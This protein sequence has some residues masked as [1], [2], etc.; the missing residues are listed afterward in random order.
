MDAP[1]MVIISLGAGVQSSVM[2]LLAAKGEITPMPDAAIFADTQWE[3]PDV[4]EHLNWLEEQLP[5]PVYRVTSGNLKE[6]SL[7]G[8]GPSKFSPVP[9]YTLNDGKVGQGRRQCTNEYKIVPV[10]KEMRRILGLKKYQRVPQSTII[11]LWFGITIDESAR[12]KPAKE[13]WIDKTYPLIGMGWSRDMCKQWFQDNYHGRHLPRSSCAGCPY[14]SNK[15]WR[16]MRDSQ[17][18]T[19]AETVEYDYS[20]RN[21]ING[22]LPQ[23]LHQTLVAL[24]VVD[25]KH[26]PPKD[27][28]VNMFVNECEGMCGV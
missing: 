15:D 8:K 27:S 21:H 13:K 14:Q 7:K 4:Y 16:E 3:P 25:L 28:Q 12:M 5:F 24:D 10:R 9:F 1:E 20:L 17:P 22:K 23:Y 2:S 6:D 19:F 18:Y 11:Q 26:D